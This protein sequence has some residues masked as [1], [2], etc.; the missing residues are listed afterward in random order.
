MNGDEGQVS[1]EWNWYL[2]IR[3][4]NINDHSRFYYYLKILVFII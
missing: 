2:F 3:N 4:F 1:N